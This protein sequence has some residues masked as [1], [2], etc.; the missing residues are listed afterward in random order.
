M[1]YTLQQKEKDDAALSKFISV[2]KLF[3]IMIDIYSTVT[4]QC[5]YF[6]HIKYALCMC[7]CM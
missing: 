6:F 1:L 4:L 2:R 7:V 5:G 3:H